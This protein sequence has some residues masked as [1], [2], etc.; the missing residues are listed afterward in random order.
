MHK[1]G[2]KIYERG[3]LRCSLSL[4]AHWPPFPLCHLHASLASLDAFS[5]SGPRTHSA[6]AHSIGSHPEGGRSSPSGQSRRSRSCRG[7]AGR[8]AGASPVL[9]PPPRPPVQSASPLHLSRAPASSAALRRAAC[10][11]CAGTLDPRPLHRLAACCACAGAQL[12]ARTDTHTRTRHTHR[13]TQRHAQRDTKR[14]KETQRDTQLADER[15]AVQSESER[16]GGART[17]K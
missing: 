16:R 14:H 12:F 5:L 4:S 17:A 3:P 15:A 11:A 10:C 6:T 8:C 13:H 1:E 2:A 7:S 9:A